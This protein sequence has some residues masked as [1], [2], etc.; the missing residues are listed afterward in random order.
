MPRIPVSIT[1]LDPIGAFVEHSFLAA[2]DQTKLVRSLRCKVPSVACRRAERLEDLTLLLPSDV[3]DH[4][5]CWLHGQEEGSDSLRLEALVSLYGLSARSYSIQL[6]PS[7][8]T[9]LLRCINSQVCLH[10]R[11]TTADAPFKLSYHSVC[12]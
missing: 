5:L 1:D 6:P 4:V 11:Y 3:V 9:L 10:V 12:N 2:P 7:Y 8:D